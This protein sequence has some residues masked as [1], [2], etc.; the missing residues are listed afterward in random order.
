MSK[1]R[2]GFLLALVLVVIVVA[3]AIIATDLFLSNMHVSVPPQPTAAS[4]FDSVNGLN[5]TLSLSSVSIQHG[6]V[7]DI[8]TDL[9]N[10]LD[11]NQTLTEVNRWPS[12]PGLSLT[13]CP[14]VQYPLGVAIYRGHFTN[15]NISTAT[16]LWMFGPAS[17]PLYVMAVDGYRFLPNSNLAFPMFQN[18]TSTSQPMRMG[19]DFNLS[20]HYVNGTLKVFPAGEYTVVSGTMWGDIAV[21]HFTVI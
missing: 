14:N 18:S 12:A 2:V 1:S 8:V 5:L 16:S 17:C 3:T 21:L 7:V 15:Q 13:P 11:H 4:S 9:T 19:A 10:T 6:Q 20:G